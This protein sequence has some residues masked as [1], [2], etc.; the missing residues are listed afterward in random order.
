VDKRLCRPAVWFPDAY[1]RRRT[2][3]N[4]P[5]ALPFQSKP[6]WAAAM[7]QAIAHEGLLPCKYVGAECLYGQSPDFL[8]AIDACIGVTAFGAIPAETRC[9]RQ[10]PRTTD[11]T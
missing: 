5:T 9:W 4:V 10:A 1:A 6:Q 11:Q 2:R 7:W 8:D 3:C